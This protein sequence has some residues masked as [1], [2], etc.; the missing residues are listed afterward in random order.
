[1]TLVRNMKSSL[2]QREISSWLLIRIVS[3]M[4]PLL[5]LMM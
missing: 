3:M 4:E 2:I 1:L 5:K